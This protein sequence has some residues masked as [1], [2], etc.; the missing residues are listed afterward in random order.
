MEGNRTESVAF[1]EFQ[2]SLDEENT[3]YI[4]NEKKI[5]DALG[6]HGKEGK[7]FC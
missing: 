7:R 6:Q 1:K 4:L 3:K 5:L 2:C